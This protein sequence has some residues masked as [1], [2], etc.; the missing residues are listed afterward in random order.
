MYEKAG[1]LDD[2]ICYKTAK[3]LILKSKV[4][5]MMT[6]SALEFLRK[7]RWFTWANAWVFVI[8][9][10]ITKDKIYGTDS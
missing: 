8:F 10:G 5:N 7:H 9:T 2:E 4:R 3:K 6:G 1:I